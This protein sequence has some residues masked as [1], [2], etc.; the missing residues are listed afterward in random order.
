MLFRSQA[1]AA[2]VQ[3]GRAYAYRASPDLAAFAEQM[4]MPLAAAGY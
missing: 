1:V 2:R 4:A 3:R